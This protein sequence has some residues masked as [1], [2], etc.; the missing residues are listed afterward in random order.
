[1][2]SAVFAGET[3]IWDS[4]D[5]ERLEEKAA[6]QQLILRSAYPG[7]GEWERVTLVKGMHGD[8]YWLTGMWLG[9][10]LV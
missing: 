6:C 3:G 2:T 9:E 5:N 1:M 4:M 10:D 8:F 7:D